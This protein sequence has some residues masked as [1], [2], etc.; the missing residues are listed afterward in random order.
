MRRAHS[1]QTIKKKKKGGGG[2]GDALSASVARAASL[3]SS[4]DSAMTARWWSCL[5]VIRRTRDDGE[6]AEH[7]PARRRTRRHAGPMVRV[8][9]RRHAD[10]ARS[11]DARYRSFRCEHGDGSMADVT[12]AAEYAAAQR[13]RWGAG[14]HGLAAWERGAA[15]SP[16]S[17]PSRTS[18]SALSALRTSAVTRRASPC[19]VGGTGHDSDQVRPDV[20]PASRR[21]GEGC[22]RRARVLRRRC[23]L[24]P[25]A[26]PSARSRRSSAS[27]CR[28]CTSRLTGSPSRRVRW[29]RSTVTSAT[30]RLSW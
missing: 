12:D 27:R 22:R 17:L 14:R 21:R 7:A 11:C 26:S 18:S 4:S 23:R 10:A 19:C 8:G 2:G 24:M 6:P 15:A 28:S 29:R 13:D 16:A 20:E 5:P 3:V 25:P 1:V 9:F 30:E